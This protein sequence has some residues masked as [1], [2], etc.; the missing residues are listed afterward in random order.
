[1][2]LNDM[3]I[4]QLTMINLTILAG[5]LFNKVDYIDRQKIKYYNVQQVVVDYKRQTIEKDWVKEVPVYKD[6]Y[7]P[8]SYNQF[9]QFPKHGKNIAIE[10]VE[11]LTFRDE[12][13]RILN[14]K[15]HDKVKALNQLYDK[16][17]T[18]SDEIINRLEACIVLDKDYVARVEKELKPAM[19]HY[20]EN[21]LPENQIM[22]G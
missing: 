11:S 5:K 14:S 2:K 21:I 10:E 18:L 3:A 1:M 22:K 13:N 4:E 12:Y 6:V 20:V 16:F 19:K 15:I 7:K 17:Y 8:I 9:K